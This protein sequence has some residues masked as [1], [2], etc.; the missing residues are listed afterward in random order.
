MRHHIYVCIVRTN[1]SLSLCAAD[2]RNHVALL[3]NPIDSAYCHKRVIAE[4]PMFIVERTQ[5]R[6][7]MAHTLIESF[8]R[9]RGSV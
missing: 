5:G 3:R 9:T 7:L 4:P 1:Y 8:V 6:E 2:T